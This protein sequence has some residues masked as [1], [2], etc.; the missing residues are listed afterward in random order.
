MLLAAGERRKVLWSQ[1]CNQSDQP[2]TASRVHDQLL[3]L[4]SCHIFIHILLGRPFLPKVRRK[5]LPAT[6]N[7]RNGRSMYR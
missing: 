6:Q 4:E 2:E 7:G 5:E 3:K 1:L